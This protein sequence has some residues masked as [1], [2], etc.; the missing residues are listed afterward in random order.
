[1]GNLYGNYLG[2]KNPQITNGGDSY[3]V[4][5]IDQLDYSAFLHDKAYD[6]C[7]FDKIICTNLCYH[8]PEI[9]TRPYFIKAD[10]SEFLATV[11]DYMNHDIAMSKVQTNTEKIQEVLRRY[12][13]RLGMEF[14]ADDNA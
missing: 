1:M 14:L 13:K 8:D 9:N 2:G 7:I 6:K 5:P 11:I 4:P 3:A 10:M 12:N